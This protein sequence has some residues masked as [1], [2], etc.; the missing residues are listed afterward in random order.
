MA[1]RPSKRD[2]NDFYHRMMVRIKQILDKGEG[3]TGQIY[4]DCLDLTKEQQYQIADIAFDH[5]RKI[6]GYDF[7]T[8]EIK[9][10]RRM[11]EE[12]ISWFLYYE[13]WQY[14]IAVLQNKNREMRANPIIDG[15]IK[16]G[17]KYAKEVTATIEEE[18]K[19]G[20]SNKYT[21]IEEW[22]NHHYK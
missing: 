17:N 16:L 12:Q 22:K 9:E 3:K 2:I 8:K 13:E 4:I 5:T 19:I 21:T 7:K 15:L 10:F 1:R 6:Y 14:E 20:S 18:I 11:V